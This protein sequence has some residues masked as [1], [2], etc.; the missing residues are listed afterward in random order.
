MKGMLNEL[1]ILNLNVTLN[2]EGRLAGRVV[3][4]LLGTQDYSF[5]LRLV[6]NLDVAGEVEL[7]LAARRAL[8]RKSVV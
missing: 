2:G 7:E 5:L 1:E 6:A 8:D 4:D 3:V